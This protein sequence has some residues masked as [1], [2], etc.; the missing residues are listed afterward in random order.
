MTLG[1]AYCPNEDLPS[2]RYLTSQTVMTM[3][4]NVTNPSASA[5]HT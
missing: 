5:T 1:V 4:I 2:D 3:S